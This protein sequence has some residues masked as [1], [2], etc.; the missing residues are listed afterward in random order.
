GTL[1]FLGKDNFPPARRLIDAGAAVAL[2]TDF[3]P[4]SSPTVNLP[5]IMSIA[6]SRLG[7]SPAEALVACTA[8]GAAALRLRD[9]RGTLEPEAP[10][11]IVA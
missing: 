9:G 5:L 6:C 8:N 4:G 3:N 2:A 1:F 11:D 10:A 7:L